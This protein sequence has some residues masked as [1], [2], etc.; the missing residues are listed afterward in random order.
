MREFKFRIWDKR[1]KTWPNDFF[2]GLDGGLI[3]DP[4]GTIFIRSDF[5]IMQ[6]TGFKDIYNKK[7]YEGDI[8][9]V[10]GNYYEVIFQNNGEWRIIR[11][12]LFREYT[13]SYPLTHNPSRRLRCE[14]L[15]RR[16]VVGN[17]YENPDL[18]KEPS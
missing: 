8:V 15:G 5:E 7:I 18:L 11:K 2:I 9:E 6:Y 1:N 14:I 16:R 12:P 13:V 4:P 10:N 17:I 3:C